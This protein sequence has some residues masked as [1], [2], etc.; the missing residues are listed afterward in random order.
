MN[1]LLKLVFFRFRNVTCFAVFFG[2]VLLG[3]QANASEKLFSLKIG[4]VWPS[5]TLSAWDAECMYGAFFDKKV[6][7]GVAADFLW[8]TYTQEQDLGNGAKLTIH[9]QSSY[10]FPVMGF[11]MFDPAPMLLVHPML[12]F[13]IGYNSLLY[14]DTSL[15]R[16]LNAPRS[17]YYYGLIVKI[18]ADGLYNLGEQVA[19]FLGL[20]YQWANTKT[21]ADSGGIFYRRDMSGIGIRMGFRFLL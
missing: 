1:Y 14:T 9:D 10:M 5:A 18:G 15:V 4:P 7:F 20:E 12:K 17:G 3:F 21:T 2:I 6:G 11:I 13:E 19:V 16:T 8:N